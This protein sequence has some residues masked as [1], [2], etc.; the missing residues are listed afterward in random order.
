GPISASLG[1]AERPAIIVDRIGVRTLLAR[2]TQVDQA[3]AAR[4]PMSDTVT[5]LTLDISLPAVRDVRGVR[6]FELVGDVLRFWGNEYH[7]TVA[8]PIA[9]LPGRFVATPDGV[10][11]EVGRTIQQ[12]DFAPGSVIRPAE[13][14]VGRDVVLTDSEG[15]NLP[16]SVQA[17]PLFDPP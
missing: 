5:R 3:G 4:G 2:I 11:I 12:N 9:W 15:Q 7:E 16:A 14:D 8:S 10:A 1:L 13:I 6:I 17:A